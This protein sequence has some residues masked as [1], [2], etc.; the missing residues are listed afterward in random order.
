MAIEAGHLELEFEPR[1]DVGFKHLCS[2][3]HAINVNTSRRELA[4]LD[5]L[6]NPSDFLC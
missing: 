6:Q 1:S 2:L 4:T 3:A 5:P